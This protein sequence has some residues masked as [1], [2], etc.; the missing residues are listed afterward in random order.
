MTEY[1]LRDLIDMIQRPLITEK[2]TRLMEQNK[3][4]FEVAH[5]ATKPEIKAAIEEL[6]KVKVLSVNTLN[7]PRKKRRVGKFAGF[8][9]RYKRAIV[10]LTEG[11]TLRGILFPEV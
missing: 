9:T 7:L 2:A 8:K 6:F 4:L 5:H 11:D 10:T 1:N 3:F